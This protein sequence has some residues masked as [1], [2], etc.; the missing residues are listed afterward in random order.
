MRSE[1]SSCTPLSTA[2]AIRRAVLRLYCLE[3]I[4]VMGKL[5]SG[6]YANVYLENPF[7]TS[8]TVFPLV[9]QYA[10]GGSLADL[11]TAASAPLP[12][13]CRVSLALDIIRGLGHLHEHRLIH[14]DLSS[15]NIL[16]R[17]NLDGS[18]APLSA[19]TCN[20]GGAGEPEGGGFSRG[21][22][23]DQL[24]ELWKPGAP[25]PPEIPK[26]S[27]LTAPPSL[28]HRFHRPAYTAVVG[29]LG[30]CLDLRQ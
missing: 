3:D 23:V 17:V 11:L 22:N 10:N 28:L 15:Q 19:W 29:D 7:F 14:R 26:I 2:E 9:L 4:S 25:P 20:C 30:V 27:P 18:V 1:Q 8:L 5:G 12:W 6:F 21:L 16:I 13:T 24:V